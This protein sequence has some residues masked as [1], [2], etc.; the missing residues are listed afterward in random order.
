MDGRDLWP[1]A[2][3]KDIGKHMASSGAF[4]IGQT[5]EW[6]SQS[7]GTTRPKR[8]VIVL[9]AGEAAHRLP[10]QPQVA[11]NPM[12]AAQALF[13]DHRLMFDGIVWPVGR[14]MVEVKPAKGKPSLYMPRLNGLRAVVE[15]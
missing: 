6:E 15:S 3:S 2:N 11:R 12:R 9:D 10:R 1:L 4:N 8:G 13:P 14:V 7:N 5:V